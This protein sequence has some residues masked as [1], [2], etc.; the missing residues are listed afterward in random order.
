[1]FNVVRCPDCGLTYDMFE[2]ENGVCPL[3][4]YDSYTDAILNN[5]VYEDSTSG[6][7]DM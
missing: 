1:M 7:E 2:S 4:G 6:D 3:C 5:A